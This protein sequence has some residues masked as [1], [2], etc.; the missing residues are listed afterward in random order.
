MVALRIETRLDLRALEH[1]DRLG[2]GLAEADREVEQGLVFDDAARLDAAARG[3][4]HFRLGVVDA[5]RE[6]LGREAAEHHRMDRADAGAG[7]HGHHRF[8][9]HRHVDQ[10]AIAGDDAEVVQDGGERR[11]LVEEL[12]VGDRPLRP[13]HRAV[14]VD[15]RLVAASVFHMPIDGVVAGV[16]PRVGKPVPVDAGLGVEDPLGRLD[17]GDLSRGLG[18][19]GLRIGAPLIIGLPVATHGFAPFAAE[20]VNVAAISRLTRPS[21]T[22]AGSN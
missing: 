20:V 4:D 22:P 14:V 13:G 19:K 12:A 15:R 11:G 21:A 16:D 17:P 3:Q 5:G 10:D 2:L 18:P 6:L 9:D 7:E 1:H 8:G